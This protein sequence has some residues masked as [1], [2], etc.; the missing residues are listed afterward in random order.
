M[1]IEKVF[2]L[3]L[4]LRPGLFKPLSLLRACNFFTR[5]IKILAEQFRRSP[6]VVFPFTCLTP[7]V[8]RIRVPAIYRIEFLIKLGYISCFPLQAAYGPHCWL[9]FSH[10]AGLVVV[11]VGGSRFQHINS[12]LGTGNKKKNIC[13]IFKR[14]SATHAVHSMPAKYSS[15]TPRTW[16]CWNMRNLF[17]KFYVDEQQWSSSSSSFYFFPLT[18]S[19]FFQFSHFVFWFKLQL[20]WAKLEKVLSKKSRCTFFYYT[21]N[22]WNVIISLYISWYLFSSWNL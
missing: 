2:P 14:P 5:E 4:R 20:H 13:C 15:K 10:L 8:L 11:Q 22:I 19:F 7:L 12:E 17:C 3:I 9:P 18:F 1:D 21:D 16:V 6:S